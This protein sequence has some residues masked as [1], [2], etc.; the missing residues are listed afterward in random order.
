[1]RVTV[2]R[3][4][5]SDM[6]AMLGLWREMMDFHARAEPRFRPAGA[7]SGEEA[8]SQHMQAD[9]WDNPEWCVLVAESRDYADRPVLVGHIIGLLRSRYPVF[10]PERYGYVSDVVVAPEARRCGVASALFAAL[11]GWFREQGVQHLELQVACQ[12][13]ASQAF[14]RAQ[15]CTD[16][17]NT[18]WHDLA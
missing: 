11:K 18:M 4:S 9:V 1:M 15:G 14:W 8:W 16:Y 5:R 17:T 2:R 6:P 3:G 13:A 7:P 10:E 12:N